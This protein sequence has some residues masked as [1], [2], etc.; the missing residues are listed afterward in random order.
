MAVALVFRVRPSMVSA[1][2][3]RVVLRIGAYLSLV[4]AVIVAWREPVL[5]PLAG[6]ATVLALAAL[7]AVQPARFRFLSVGA[8][9]AYTLVIVATALGEGGVSGIPQLCLTASA[10]LTVAIVTTYLPRVGARAWQAVL[11]VATVPFGIGVL[12]VVVERSGWTALSTGLMFVLA[13]SLLFTRRPGLTLA[14][15][16]AAAAMP[17][18]ALAV[19]IVCLGA[20]LLATSGS[21][22]VLPLIAVVVALALSSTGIV[23]GGLRR[24]GHSAR[25]AGAAVVA[26]EASALLT[27]AIAVGLAL[28]RD[29][30][31]VGTAFLVLLILGIGASSSALLAGRAHA[32]W[33][34]GASFTGALWCLW[35]I[36]G[37]DVLEAYLL[38]P[39]LGAALVA[40]VITLRGRRATALFATGLAVAICPLLAILCVVEPDG[41]SGTSV[42]WRVGGLLVAAWMLLGLSALVGRPRAGARV[43]RLRVLRVPLLLAGGLASTAGTIAAVRIGLGWDLSGAHGAGLFLACLG[44][45]AVAAAVL[46]L[47]GDGIRRAVPAGSALR[48]SRWLGAPA[49]LALA[50]GTWFAIERDWFSIWSLWTVMLALLIAVVVSARGAVRGDTALPPVWFLFA[51]AFVTAVVAWSPRDLRVEWFSLPLGAFLLMAGMLGL[52][53]AGAEPGERRATLDSWPGRWRGSWALLAPGLVTMLS[54]SIVSTFTDP[55]TWRAILVMVLALIAIL[56]GSARRS[57]APFL[58]GIIVLPIENVFVFAVQIGRGIASMPWWITLAVVGAVLLIIAVTAERRAGEGGS[59]AARLRDLR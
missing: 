6:V 47:A 8:G 4:C 58:I 37:V 18:P 11:A 5:V 32:W 38:P 30:A 16:T 48:R 35:S 22:V 7:A 54:A 51:V 45:S 29:A 17:V 53:A 13:V 50:G 36:A 40:V 12:Q 31:G 34:A 10:G 14:V 57:A 21:P 23:R 43:R 49:V 39:T 55:L 1:T 46:A 52:R 33:A 42:A 26:I 41:A 56:A 44:V 24:R 15:R 28:W 59:V 2:G 25:V 27:G 19:V 3:V 9:F 20:Q